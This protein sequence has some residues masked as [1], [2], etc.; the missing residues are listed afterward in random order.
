MD[1][2]LYKS[3]S[4]YFFYA[5]LYNLIYEDTSLLG[6]VFMT[7]YK[8][9]NDLNYGDINR[10]L[11]REYIVALMLEFSKSDPSDIPMKSN[12]M[13]SNFKSIKETILCYLYHLYYFHIPED[14]ETVKHFISSVQRE[15]NPTIQRGFYNSAMS[16]Y[17]LQDILFSSNKEVFNLT[18]NNIHSEQE[19]LSLFELFGHDF[20]HSHIIDVVQDS[21]TSQEE[22]ESSLYEYEYE[23]LSDYFNDSINT[24]PLSRELKH[25][26]PGMNIL[27]KQD[28][29]LVYELD[30]W[31]II[32]IQYINIYSEHLSNFIE[33]NIDNVDAINKL[34]DIC[35]KL[36]PY[37]LAN[38]VSL[39]T[40][41]VIDE[42]SNFHNGRQ[43]FTLLFAVVIDDRELSEFVDFE[44]KDLKQLGVYTNAFLELTKS[45]S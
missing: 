35:Y 6:G 15:L 34:T 32:N 7:I 37:Y 24:Y 33:E 11:R 27:S 38:I 5:T 17:S 25:Y 44:A 31:G 39:S 28:E 8:K 23:R 40:P 41:I 29:Y 16:D 45:Q 12:Y 9:L 26:A 21:P 10:M 14:R 2:L 42:S 18:E 3:L 19:L 1:D 36:L 22:F 30:S 20:I 13:Y 43:K 4:G